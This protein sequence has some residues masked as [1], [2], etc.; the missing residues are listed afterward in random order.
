MKRA[1]LFLALG[2]AGC[3]GAPQVVTRVRVERIQI[4]AALLAD[5]PPPAPPKRN[6]SSDI[7]IWLAQLWADDAS[8]TAQLS[9]I[10]NLQISATSKGKHP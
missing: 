2:L 4:P 5:P 6:A 10:A 7:S 3:S 8:K 1:A 9:A